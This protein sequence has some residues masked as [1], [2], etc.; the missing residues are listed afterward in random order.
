M[1]GADVNFWSAK[2]NL[3]ESLVV[4]SRLCRQLSGRPETA[5]LGLIEAIHPALSVRYT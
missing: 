5:G 3:R 2:L 1:R 4:D